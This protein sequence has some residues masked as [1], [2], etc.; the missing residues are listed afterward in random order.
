MLYETQIP[1]IYIRN[2]IATAKLCKTII[3]SHNSPILN[4]I[5]N[6]KTRKKIKHKSTIDRIISTARNLGI[7]HTH[8]PRNPIMHT[9][10]W[11]LHTLSIDSSLRDYP[12]TSTQP[13]IYRKL[14]QEILDS[15]KKY[16]GIFTDGSQIND[17][18]AYAITSEHNI[19]R[20]GIIPFFSTVFSAEAIAITEALNIFKNKP[21]KYAIYTD[22]LST[23]DAI[24]NTSNSDYYPSII[25]NILTK[26]HPKFKIIWIPGHIGIR[27][28]ELA[29]LASKNATKLPLI[30]T[31]NYNFQDIK[32]YLK[33]TLCTETKNTLHITSN[34]CQSTHPN[35]TNTPILD[36]SN[37]MSR[38]DQIIITRLRLGHT[39]LTHQHY[40]DP[41]LDNTCLFCRNTSVLIAYILKECPKPGTVII[42]S[43][44]L[45]ISL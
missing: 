14:F 1:P 39:N 19:I 36:P 40:L 35:M 11:H 23:I 22:S 21:G 33:N 45:K 32:K 44:I 2:Q 15:N 30:L 29:A 4:I 9:P 5:K 37:N 8:Y 26:H 18:T 24:K 28:N 12:K 10:P 6:H 3:N 25:R 42:I 27:G 7:P 41:S 13:L 20:T 31:P 38:Y 17:I 43:F 16:K 34:W